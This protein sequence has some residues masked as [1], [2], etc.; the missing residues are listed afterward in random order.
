MGEDAETVETTGVLR[1]EL[2]RA[3]EDPLR[4]GQSALIVVRQPEVE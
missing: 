1:I 2:Q 3:S 4:L